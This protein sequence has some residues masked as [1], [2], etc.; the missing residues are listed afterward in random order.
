MKVTEQVLRRL[1]RDRAR[2]N[3]GKRKMSIDVDK[4]MK[5]MFHLNCLAQGGAERVVTNLSGQFA[6]EGNDVIVATEWVDKNEFKLND[7]VRRVNAGLIPE[8]EKK[9][10]IGKYFARGKRLKECIDREKPDVVVA[11][12]QS[13]LYRALKVE[14]KGDTPV[15]IAVRT[16]PKG[17]YDRPVDK[18]MIRRYF[19]CMAGGVFQTSQQRDFF[20]PY[21]YE[22][23]SHVILNPVNEKYFHVPVPEHRTNRVVTSGR[24]V[25]FKNQ[26]LLIDAF[27][28]VHAKHPD[29]VL[30]IYGED[31]F[32]GTKDILDERISRYHAE[33]YVHLMGGSDELEKVMRDAAVYAFSSDWE[34]LPNALMEAMAMGLPV[35]A[36]DC[37]CGGPGEIIENEKNG[38]LIPIMDP[39]A[40]SDGIN[41]L[42]EDR[43]LAEGL[44][45][46]ARKIKDR[47]NGEIVYM[48]WRD[49][50]FD[51][52]KAFDEKHK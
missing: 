37:P 30:E 38:L 29:Y 32:D 52:I 9:N 8:D 2:E 34:G 17:H 22:E 43:E 46:E 23:N 48:Q 26:K 10:R 24:L 1:L 13:A 16:D 14:K 39:K 4:K 7:K 35:V 25:D 5:I 12:A 40:L 42:I 15:V 44:G 45:R 41:R 28:D 36:T 50:L 49:F 27:E 31:S 18:I 19:P 33:S 11:F 47:A 6:E 20:K 21:C 51:R 3:K